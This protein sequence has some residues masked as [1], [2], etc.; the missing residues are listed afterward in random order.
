MI[1]QPFPSEWDTSRLP[2]SRRA[3]LDSGLSFEQIVARAHAEMHVVHFKLKPYKDPGIGEAR[4]ARQ[5]IFLFRISLETCDL[6]YN[7]ADGLR[8]RYWQSPDHGFCA[9]RHL[10]S[11]MTSVFLDFAKRNDPVGKC[12]AAD[13]TAHDM[14]AS[15]EAPSAK[16]WPRERSENGDSLFES[17]DLIV[18]R[19]D[20]NDLASPSQGMWRRTPTSGE[21]EVKGAILG[22]DATEYLPEGKRDR[23][24]QIH[25]FGFT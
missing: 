2:G 8:G 24:W 21:L 10:L 6:L 9:T 13:M 19:W 4:D 23:S 12:R 5:V 15:L 14:R 22:L 25:R 11:A 20:A 7:A 16:V 18:R 1:R 17:H 3:Y